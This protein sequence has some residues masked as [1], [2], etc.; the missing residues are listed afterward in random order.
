MSGQVVIA[1]DRCRRW[2]R[3]S[4]AVPHVVRSAASG[5]AADLGGR[6]SRTR[7]APVRGPCCGARRRGER[8]CRRRAGSVTSA[9]VMGG[10]ILL[11]ALVRTAAQ[12]RTAGVGRAPRPGG[13][14]SCHEWEEG[15]RPGSELLGRWCLVS[16]RRHT[17][18]SR[19]GSRQV[20]LA[21]SRTFT[22]PDGA[23]SHRGDALSA[24][25]P[26][27]LHPRRA[28]AHL[29]GMPQHRM[30][31][32]LTPQ[33]ADSASSS[34]RSVEHTPV[35]GRSRCTV[36]AAVRSPARAAATDLTCS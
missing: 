2:P 20:R 28:I 25:A 32:P 21:R 34:T 6:S 31:Q 29:E 3:A 5:C 4:G 18:P 23:H 9:V 16:T 1:W 7:V 35:V 11:T 22:A 24:I 12:V 30:P 10:R 36:S 26:E 15:A 8:D 13:Q 33:Q 27:D 19:P 17:D 14:A